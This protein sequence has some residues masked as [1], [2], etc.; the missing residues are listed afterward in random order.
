M[1]AFVGNASAEQN[2][3]RAKHVRQIR[4]PYGEMFYV[5][6]HHFLRSRVAQPR[7][8]KC[9]FSVYVFQ[10]PACH[11]PQITICPISAPALL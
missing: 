2:S 8:G 11:F 3:L 5:F 7:G 6:V 9:G 4:K 1:F 10:F